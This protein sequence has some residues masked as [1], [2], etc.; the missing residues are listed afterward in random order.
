MR[1][2]KSVLALVLALTLLLG[3]FG[4]AFAAK[5]T[6]ITDIA[7]T[8]TSA[9]TSDKSV[10]KEVMA[11]FQSEEFKAL[12]TYKYADDEIVRAIIILEGECEADVAEAGSEKAAAQRVKLVNEHNAVRKAMAGINFEM[13]YEFTT[14]L[15]G[16]SCD[17]AYGDL[18]AIYGKYV[19][20]WGGEATVWRLD[21][22]VNGNVVCSRT[23]CPSAKLH[24]EAI[25]SHT[26]LT[27][28]DTYDMAAIRIR[29][30]DEYG[31]P[32]PYAQL[33]ATF[34][35]E[36]AA[37]LVGPGTATAE[38]GMCGTYIRT[39]GQ[40]GTA[41]LTISTPQTEEITLEFQIS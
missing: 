14:L 24:L 26:E 32:A 29:V 34:R 17:V 11:G 36:G 12:N 35:L 3:C 13:K 9:A 18:E 1:T 31:N 41:R 28:G 6:Q 2:F 23:L 5:K 21:A 10:K 25:P 27:E 15:N 19:G 37:E 8:K 33:P 20:N 16:F 40:S 38:G 30:L 7:G 39:A 22:K 4:T